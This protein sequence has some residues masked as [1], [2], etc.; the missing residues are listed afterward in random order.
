MIWANLPVSDVQRTEAFYTA[1]GIRPNTGP[2]SPELTSFLFG[3]NDFPIHFFRRDKLEA[4]MNDKA[5][6]SGS[7]SEVV[8]SLWAEIEE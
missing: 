2:A 8:F 7:G 6:P 1:L 4:S 5:I 3:K